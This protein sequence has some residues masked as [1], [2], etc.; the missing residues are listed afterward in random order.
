MTRDESISQLKSIEW[1]DV[2]LKGAAWRSPKEA[3]ST[4]IKAGVK[5]KTLSEQLASPR[6]EGNGY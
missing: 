6:E 2:E 1:S 5:L 4:S 3:P